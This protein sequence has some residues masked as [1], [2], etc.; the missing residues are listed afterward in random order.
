MGRD[1]IG[2]DEMEPE[3]TE[4]D[5]TGLG[6][7]EQ[8]GTRRNG[9]EEWDK[10]RQEENFPLIHVPS[11]SVT[12]FPFPSPIPVPSLTIESLQ[13]GRSFVFSTPYI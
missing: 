7:T 11:R 12:S 13:I 10:M 6:D 9:S 3:R 5:M 4:R 1:G 8:N 2:Q